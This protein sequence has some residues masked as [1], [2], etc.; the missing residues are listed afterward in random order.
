MKSY[1][2][3]I[4]ESK[5]DELEIKFVELAHLDKLEIKFNFITNVHHLFYFY[6]D[7]CLFELS[8]K[9]LY[10]PRYLFIN[11]NDIWS[12]FAKWDFDYDDIQKLITKLGT[13]YFKFDVYTN[14]FKI[15]VWKN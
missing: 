12:K 11:Y 10:N 4:N 3:Y 13:K 15:N 6:N 5:L 9:T 1:I 14:W 7:T 2:N 8:P